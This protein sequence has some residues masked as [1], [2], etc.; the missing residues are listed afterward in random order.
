MCGSHTTS[1]ALPVAIPSLRANTILRFGSLEF[2][3]LG[4]G[5]NMALLSPNC[6]RVEATCPMHPPVRPAEPASWLPAPNQF[7][8][9]APVDAVHIARLVA[10]PPCNAGGAGSE[11]L[12]APTTRD[13][14]WVPY[15]AVRPRRR[16]PV[17]WE[18]RGVTPLRPIRVPRPNISGLGV[19]WASHMPRGLRVRRRPRPTPRAAPSMW[20]PEPAAVPA[21][22]CV[23]PPSY[24]GAAPYRCPLH[25]G[26]GHP[27][28]PGRTT[29]VHGR[30]VEVPRDH[31]QSSQL[32]REERLRHELLHPDAVAARLAQLRHL[33]SPGRQS[34]ASG[35]PMP[36]SP[37]YMPGPNAPRPPPSAAR[38]QGPTDPRPAFQSPR[39]DGRP[40]AGPSYS[41]D[42]KGVTWKDVQVAPRAGPPR[43]R[44]K[45]RAGQP[46]PAVLGSN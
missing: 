37:V 34:G 14:R 4:E 33:V 23:P 29:I 19:T 27:L 13:P 21:R 35:A 38:P 45:K 36:P 1:M 11:L 16:I 12:R 41:P 20:A 43:R 40:D 15:L 28:P 3:A 30:P 17:I 10:I 44:R 25:A 32:R 18:R 42:D 31:L 8:T 2:I 39:L 5:Y 22:P 7:A 24:G 46:A 6:H 26:I 9:G